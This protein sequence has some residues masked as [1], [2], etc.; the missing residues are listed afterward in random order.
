MSE[1]DIS[2]FEKRLTNV[3]EKPLESQDMN[4]SA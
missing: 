2:H 3:K 1:F 4:S